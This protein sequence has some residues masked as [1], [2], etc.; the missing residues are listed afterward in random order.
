MAS[1]K[2]RID[3]PLP[4]IAALEAAASD[5]DRADLLAAI[6]GL[7]L[8]PEN[9]ERIVR[10]EALAY[11]VA[12]GK[13]KRSRRIA[14]HIL[15]RL[16][17]CEALRSIAHAEDPFDSVFCEEIL[18]HGGSYRVLPGITEHA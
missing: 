1:P 4:D 13:S 11:I 8:M 10:L 12:S 2:E 7:Q 14:P 3:G 18:F 6:A 16:C 15:T 5:F 9:A 17:N